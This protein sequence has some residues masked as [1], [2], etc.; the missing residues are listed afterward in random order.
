MV[1]KLFNN[2]LHPTHARLLSKK[3]IMHSLRYCLPFSTNNSM[4]QHWRWQS[5]SKIV[6]CWTS[7][8]IRF[9][10]LAKKQSEPCLHL[11]CLNLRLHCLCNWT[12]TK[13]MRFSF[14]LEKQTGNFHEFSFLEM[15]RQLICFFINK[16]HDC[17]WTLLWVPDNSYSAHAS[18]VIP[19]KLSY[20]ACNWLLFPCYPTDNARPPDSIDTNRRM[21]FSTVT[22]LVWR[23]L[24]QMDSKRR[25]I[26]GRIEVLAST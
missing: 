10:N 25:T 16:E 19:H 17:D 5:I 23:L 2:S 1:M 7:C 4:I 11:T 8:G 9:W 18:C 24:G 20:T 21:L 3:R 12:P 6:F 14:I 15:S 26:G 22:L 13:R